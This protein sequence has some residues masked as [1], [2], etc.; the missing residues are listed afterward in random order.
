MAKPKTL[1]D[2]VY[3]WVEAGYSISEIAEWC[4]LSRQHLYSLMRGVTQRPTADTIH[5]LSVGLGTSTDVVQKAL[6]ASRG[7]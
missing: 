5:R 4:G 7:K 3:G 1:K 6:R 2:L